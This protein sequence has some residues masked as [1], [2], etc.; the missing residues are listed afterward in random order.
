MS[1]DKI[2]ELL[3]E[4]LAGA[5][6]NE[7]TIFNYRGVIRRFKAYCREN[8]I[9]EY[10]P[11]AGQPYA[12]DVISLKTGKFSN[13]RYHTQGR[14]IR[15]LNSYYY[16]GEFN[17]E[18]MKRGKVKPEDPIHLQI[19]DDYLSFLSETYDNENTRHFYEYG[20]YS[21]LQYMHRNS[22][23]DTEDLSVEVIYGYLAESKPERLREIL[24]ELRSI[25][26]YLGREDLTSSI[27]GIHGPRFKRIIP[28]LTDEELDR[29]KN[30][31]DQNAIS[32]RD[33]AIVL[34]G[35]TCGIRA[36]DL[37]KLK[38]SDIDWSNETISFRQSKT[39]NMVCLPLTA[40]VGNAIARYLCEER[41][42]ADNDYLFVRQLAPFNP[43][44][45]HASCHAIVTRVFRKA[46][47]SKDSRIFGMHMLRHNA[48]ST[49]VKNQ[50][51]I[52][53]IAA[54][55]GHSS[56]DTTDIYI[57]TDAERL[58]ECVLPMVNISTEVLP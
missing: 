51:P 30:V 34:T 13:N 53:T 32:L 44:T 5:G 17:F 38:L 57:T 18:M 49:M 19:Y 6:Y 24:C 22:I 15:L 25:F 21:L 27:A 37:I 50:V 3:L 1:I 42:A 28:T 7:S 31:I 48:A 46:G 47:I 23:A 2:C 9:T 20:M 43:F 40:A 39:G 8:G 10:T 4:A 56:P 36:C 14:F 26:R 52:E 11:D 58:R 45:D 41:P 12:D 54:I 29:I 35:L 16:N 55:L 33:G